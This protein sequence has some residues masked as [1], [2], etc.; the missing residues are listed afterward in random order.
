[1]VC[2]AAAEKAP[3]ASIYNVCDGKPSTMTHY[4]KSV[5]MALGLPL[6]PEIDREQAEKELSAGMLSYLKESRRINNTRLITELAITL[7]YP[8]L[9]AGLAKLD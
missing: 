5:A 2:V 8:D 9:M 3:N 4:F 1:M 7:Q 6:P